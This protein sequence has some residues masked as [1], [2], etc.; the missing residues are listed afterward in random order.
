MMLLLL[1]ARMAPL[2]LAW[3]FRALMVLQL[4]ACV[5][6]L[7]RANCTRPR[8]RAPR[9]IA[10]R[11][12]PRRAP[13]PSPL[14]TVFV[15]V[16]KKCLAVRLPRLGAFGEDALAAVAASEGCSPDD[17][18]LI[19]GG[20]V[21]VPRAALPD[22]GG[23]T[24]CYYRYR[25]PAGGQ[26]EALLRQ[27]AF[28]LPGAANATPVPALAQA[29]SSSGGGAQGL[30]PSASIHDVSAFGTSGY[31]LIELRKDSAFTA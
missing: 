19:C 28:D 11:R 23:H 22:H 13:R 10:P 18:Y 14:R 9:W 31:V 20:K 24:T 12:A 8:L 1:L 4:H 6:G 25:G 21:I 7:R 2:G 16:G 17:G 5:R 27:L 15:H 3:G 29:T 26:T 30:N